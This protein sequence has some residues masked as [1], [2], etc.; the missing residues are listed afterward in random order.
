MRVIT[1]R[2]TMLAGDRSQGVAEAKSRRSRGEISPA[3]I[4]SESRNYPNCAHWRIYYFMR[5]LCIYK[6]LCV[7]SNTI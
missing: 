1:R 5:L 3:S 6:F 7:H 4:L 2:A